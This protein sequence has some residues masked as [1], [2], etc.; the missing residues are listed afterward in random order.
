[1]SK[2]SFLEQLH[3]EAALQAKLEQARFLPRELDFITSFVA[4][5]SLWVLLILSCACALGT[6]FITKYVW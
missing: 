5:H 1:M 3:T 4:N 2:S 6:Q